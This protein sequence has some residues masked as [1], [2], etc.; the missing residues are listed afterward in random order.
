MGSAAWDWEWARS[1]SFPKT[2]ANWKDNPNDTSD[3]KCN[4]TQQRA[5][6]SALARAMIGRINYGSLPYLVLPMTINRSAFTFRLRMRVVTSSSRC[7]VTM[8]TTLFG[9][10][11]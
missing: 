8:P 7:S 10:S 2:D 4:G 5:R 3:S 11:G 9:S 6:P 1:I